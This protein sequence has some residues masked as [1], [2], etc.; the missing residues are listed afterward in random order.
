MITFLSLLGVFIGS[1]LLIPH[2]YGDEIKNTVIGQLNDRLKVEVEVEEVDLSVLRKFPYASV[3]LSNVS[4]SKEEDS[5]F[6]FQEVYLQFDITDLFSKEQRIERI[7][8]E[9]GRVQLPIDA[10]GKH[11]YKDIWRTEKKP[12]DSGSSF[13]L[14]RMIWKNV[15]LH[16]T[17]ARNG[18]SFKTHISYAFLQGNFDDKKSEL[19]TRVEGQWKGLHLKDRAWKGLDRSYSLLA[20]GTLDNAKN[21]IEVDE[22]ELTWNDLKG[23]LNGN[24]RFGAEARVD[25][26]Y[27]FPSHPIEAYLE[28]WPGL[29]V[30]PEEYEV[31]A[32]MRVEGNW[33][34][35]TGEGETPELK[36]KM[37]IDEG[38]VEHRASGIEAS[39][40]RARGDFS[41]QNASGRPA[42]RLK[43]FSGK[44]GGGEWKG[45]G[46]WSSGKEHRFEVHLNGK[47]RVKETVRFLGIDTV[48][49]ASGKWEASI[50][51]K[52]RL[53][54]LK[55]PSPGELEASSISG[56]AEL[57]DATLAIKGSEN[58]ISGVDGTFLLHGMD[59]AVEDLSGDLSGSDFELKG[60]F[61]ELLP[62]LFYP[63]RTMKVKA[64]FG[65]DLLDLDRLLKKSENATSDASKSYKLKFPDDL[66]FQLNADIQAL[67]FRHFRPRDLSGQLELGPGGFSGE[68][69][70]MKL[71]KGRLDGH[72]K[73]NASKVPYE[74]RA[75]AE[76]KGIHIAPFFKA[77]ESFGQET[78]RPQHLKGVLDAGIRF[79]STLKK[80]LG[81]PA[82]SVLSTAD[83]ELRKGELIQFDPLLDLGSELVDKKVL[84]SFLDLEGLAEELQHVRFQTLENRIRIEDESVIIP[85]FDVH[86]NALDIT[87][88]GRHGFDGRI[89]HHFVILMDDLLSKPKKS[90]FGYLKDEGNKKRLFVKMTGTTED[91]NISFD[92]EAAS[93]FRKKRRKDEKEEVKDA[94]RKEFGLFGGKDSSSTKEKEEKDKGEPAFEV[95][96]GDEEKKKKKKEKE[97]EDENLWDRLG[98]DDEEEK[99]EDDK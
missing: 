17:D 95:S 73:V 19:R 88:S 23:E 74:V 71:A 9:D 84:N 67:K 52:S 90:E 37:E 33:V 22:A 91:P 69:I 12:K 35:K 15:D 68:E 29:S 6:H 70:S 83:I 34:G 78:I 26:Q 82:A 46:H 51:V 38:N 85:R 3:A 20:S 93:K 53:S 7:S 36:G 99:K 8:F 79:S 27:R 89:D 98:G 42:I 66:H 54:D 31:N 4:L 61:H 92:R 1:G 81:I 43:E 62:Y 18:S 58:Q 77:F 72:L 75:G 24:I 50:R 96:W 2:F 63:D 11:P 14:E 5:L 55:K 39:K 21:R 32:D 80:D 86:S 64:E 41:T 48:S 28:A 97:K 76:L 16:F 45:K 10:R 30:L 65:S 59:A 44:L 49:K 25:L 13:H 56:K 94:L 40:L 57:K 60:R 87:A 47:S